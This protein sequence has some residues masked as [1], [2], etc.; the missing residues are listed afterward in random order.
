MNTGAWPYGGGRGRAFC[1]A[2]YWLHQHAKRWGNLGKESERKQFDNARIQVHRTVLDLFGLFVRDENMLEADD[3]PDVYRS[4]IAYALLEQKEC[5]ALKDGD[6]ALAAAIRNGLEKVDRVADAKI[7]KLARQF[8][9]DGPAP[10]PPLQQIKWLSTFRRLWNFAQL[11]ESGAQESLGQE[12][13]AS[14]MRISGRVRNAFLRY[15]CELSQVDTRNNMDSVTEAYYRVLW[16]KACKAEGYGALSISRRL[17]AI[18]G[19]TKF[20]LQSLTDRYGASGAP[21]T[22]AGRQ[23]PAGGELEALTVRSPQPLDPG[24]GPSTIAVSGSSGQST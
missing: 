9:I 21:A 15:G 16:Q 14:K 7:K 2:N 17:W 10:L 11:R 8:V 5:Q 24:P 22:R 6:C 1:D 4:E 19:A 12:V 23:Q 20:E 18:E 3:L 13:S